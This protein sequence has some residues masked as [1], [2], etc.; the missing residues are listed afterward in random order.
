MENP[1]GTRIGRQLTSSCIVI[2]YLICS[3]TH[4]PTPHRGGKQTH[5]LPGGSVLVQSLVESDPLD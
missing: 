4:P 3:N 2:E 5:Q 1:H